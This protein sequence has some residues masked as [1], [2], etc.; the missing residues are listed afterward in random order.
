MKKRVLFIFSIFV[1]AVVI[2]LLYNIFRGTPKNVSS[3]SGSIKLIN[4]ANKYSI[5]A[6]GTGDTNTLTDGNSSTW[7]CSNN[8]KWPATL[9]I[10]LPEK[11][12][13]LDDI[14]IKFLQEPQYPNRSI[15]L[16]VQCEIVGKNTIATGA[17]D[18]KLFNNEYSYTFP[19]NTLVKKITITL[20]NPK[21]SKSVGKF[22]PAL[23]EIEIYSPKF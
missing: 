22:W 7:W 23:E 15:D 12:I 9:T 16:N 21:E 13:I 4:I 19:E 17:S 1:L 2:V 11:G 10:A 5:I 3:A 18:C 6:D 20:N 14:V 8:N